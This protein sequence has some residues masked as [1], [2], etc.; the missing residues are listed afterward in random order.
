MARKTL[1]PWSTSR[2]RTTKLVRVLEHKCD[3]EWLRELGLFDGEKKGLREDLTALYSLKR[4]CSEVEGQPFL[5]C[6]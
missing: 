5:L 3:G 4:D 1:R 2:E 6:N